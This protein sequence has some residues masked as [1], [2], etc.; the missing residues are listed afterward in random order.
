[1]CADWDCYPT[2]WLIV[3]TLF[4][5]IFERGRTVDKTNSKQNRKMCSAHFLMMIFFESSAKNR[6]S[7]QVFWGSKNITSLTF[8]KVFASLESSAEHRVEN[9]DSYR[10]YCCTGWAS[11]CLQSRVKDRKMTPPSLSSVAFVP[12]CQSQKV[13]YGLTLNFE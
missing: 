13:L 3:M 8:F 4:F 12:F 9:Q 10:V 7:C 11:G 5:D 2:W 1:M 6:F